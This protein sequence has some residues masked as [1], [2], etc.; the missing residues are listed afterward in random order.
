MTLEDISKPRYRKHFNRLM[1]AVI[2]AL[3]GLALGISQLL[4]ALFPNAEGSHFGH[5][6][7][8]VITAGLIVASV[9][10]KYRYHPAM[11]E[12]MYVWNLKQELNRIYRKQKKVLAAVDEGDR[13]AM[14]IMNFSYQGSRQLYELDDNTV[15]MDD[16]EKALKELEGKIADAGYEVTLEDYRSSLLEKY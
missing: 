8:G 2:I 6:I 11:Y 13:D 12:V 3:F 7:S 9:I 5:N 1:I 15:T 16:L 4:I 10:Y 14:I